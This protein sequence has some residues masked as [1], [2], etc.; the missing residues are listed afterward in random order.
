MI[1]CYNEE[2]VVSSTIK[3]LLDEFSRSG[4]RLEVIAVDNGSHDKTGEILRNWAVKTSSVIHHRVDV[5]EGYGKGVLCGLPLATAPWVGIIP[6]DGQVD[7]VDV[8]R[9]YEVAASSNGWAKA[10]PGRSSRH[11]T[12]TCSASPP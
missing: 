3:R 7:A 4:Y 8:V 9:L 12:S 10:A 2:G 5:N 11:V 6:A 1:P